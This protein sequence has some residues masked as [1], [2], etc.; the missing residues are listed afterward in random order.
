MY[1][2]RDLR[3][4]QSAVDIN[5]YVAES[6][7]PKKLS[8]PKSLDLR[9]WLPKVRDQLSQGLSA[10]YCVAT[11]KEYQENI[12]LGIKDYM[13]P[14]YL[15][16]LTCSDG[17]VCVRNVFKTLHKHGICVEKEY[18]YGTK[19]QPHPFLMAGSLVHSIDKFACIKSIN[20]LKIALLQYGPCV[21]AF[22]VY[23]K[24]SEMWRPLYQGQQAKGGHA[25]TVV[26]YNRHGFILRNSWG[27]HWGD[28]GHCMYKYEDWG[29]HW[30][31]WTSILDS[32]LNKRRNCC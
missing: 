21:I 19:Q 6:F 15:E 4:T 7:L 10:A 27:V 1:H 32:R 30:E 12:Q 20:A 17:G 5:D 22:P 9:K 31:I 25:M 11:M 28:K 13:S 26:G 16:N 29:M 24:T 14:Q 8:V 18:P 2:V 3:L 23:T